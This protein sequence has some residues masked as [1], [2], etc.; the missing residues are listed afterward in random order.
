MAGTVVSGEDGITGFTRRFA[1]YAIWWS[2]Y[3]GLVRLQFCNVDVI[4]VSL[5]QSQTGI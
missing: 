2:R 4:I 1:G 3:F 5:P